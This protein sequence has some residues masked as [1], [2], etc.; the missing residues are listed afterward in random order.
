MEPEQP[1]QCALRGVNSWCARSELSGAAKFRKAVL[2]LRWVC[3][4][5]AALALQGAVGQLL[6]HLHTVY[7]P[8]NLSPLYAGR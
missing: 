2:R 8:N 7:R 3:A 5:G 6:E 4:E 1:G